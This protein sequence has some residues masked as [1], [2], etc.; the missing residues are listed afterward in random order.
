MKTIVGRRNAVAVSPRPRRLSSVIAARI[1]R[2][3]GTVADARLG[4]AE[5]SAPTP[6]AI[7]TA[8]V[9]V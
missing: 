6:A 8:T 1:P 4:K 3:I 7:D 9:R 2:Q 5:T